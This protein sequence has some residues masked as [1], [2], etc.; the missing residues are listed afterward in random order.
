MIKAALVVQS[1]D[2]SLAEISAVMERE[3]DHGYDRGSLSK[4]GRVLRPWAP[5][6]LDLN[7]SPGAHA[8]TE[9][10]AEAIESLGQPVAERA[11]ILVARGCEVVISV[12]QE[13]EDDPD[14]AGLH[15]SPRAIQWMASASAAVDV[16]QYIDSG[17]G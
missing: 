1:R 3:P 15:P 16:D 4:V 13:I 10:L 7:L 5:W 2:L 8:G 6:S 12:F 9:G 14:S 17:R 11:A